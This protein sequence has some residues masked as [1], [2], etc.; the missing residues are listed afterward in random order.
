MP[1]PGSAATLKFAIRLPPVSNWAMTFSLVVTRI[2]PAGPNSKPFGVKPANLLLGTTTIGLPVK[3][4]GRAKIIAGRR[5][6]TSNRVLLDESAREPSHLDIDELLDR[7]AAGRRDLAD[8]DSRGIVAARKTRV[9]RTATEVALDGRDEVIAAGRGVDREEI[10]RFDSV[11]AA[12]LS[13][14]MMFWH[15]LA[16]GSQAMTVLFLV[17]F[18]TTISPSSRT[19][20]GP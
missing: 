16:T 15:V 5:D 12:A 7:Q 4:C 18:A 10:A 1:W 2:V 8:R 3:S 9:V 6:S 13:R 17:A 20:P 19:C 11:T 14:A